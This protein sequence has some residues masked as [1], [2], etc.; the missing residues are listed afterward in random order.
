MP[1]ETRTAHVRISGRVQAVGFRAWTERNALALGLSGWVR[2]RRNGTVE[3]V[4]HGAFGAVAEMLALCERGPG[5][6]HV[7]SVEVSEAEPE[8]YASFEVRPTV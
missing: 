8:V 6:A 2:N 7:S 1:A 4:F 3:A 5:A